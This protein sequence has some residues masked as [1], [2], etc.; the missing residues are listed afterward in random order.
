MG[1]C[2]VESDDG[3]RDG[4]VY[5]AAGGDGGNGGGNDVV[6]GI[7]RSSLARSSIKERERERGGLGSCTEEE[8]PVL[9]W[10]SLLLS[11]LFLLLS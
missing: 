8:S 3:G 4:G 2:L 11:S 7:S 6:L 1:R 9:S 10:L 5:G